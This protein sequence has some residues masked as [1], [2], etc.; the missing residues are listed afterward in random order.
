MVNG[1]IV[2]A[3][4]PTIKKITHVPRF[5][6]VEEIMELTDAELYEGFSCE[7]IERTKREVHQ[8][9][10]PQQVAE[11]NRRV[12]KM[13]KEQWQLIKQEG[14]VIS[15][16]M[17]EKMDSE[18]GIPPV[19]AVIARHHAWTQNFYPAGADVYRGLGHLYV[20]HEEFRAH[21]DSYRTGLA[22]FMKASMD[23]F[24]EHTLN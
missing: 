10:D 15:R 20:E 2:I 5:F 13:S 19:Q 22:D 23:T 11:A 3:I 18:P 14:E 24:C 8:R 16:L 12:R 21:Y 9:Y 17:A 7:Q 4:E 1:R 6:G